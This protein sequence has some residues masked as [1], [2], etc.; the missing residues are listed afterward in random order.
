MNILVMRDL[1]KDDRGNYYI[2]VGQVDDQLTLVNAFV[3]FSFRRILFFNDDFKKRICGIRA[4]V[5]R[6][7]SA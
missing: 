6:E 4:R 3:E 7:T 2:A 1:I 5:L